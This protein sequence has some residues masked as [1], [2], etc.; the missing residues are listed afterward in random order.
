MVTVPL[1]T[2]HSAITDPH[3]LYSDHPNVASKIL[4]AACFRGREERRVCR[5]SASSISLSMRG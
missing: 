2:Q 1:S 5:G 3:A 4:H